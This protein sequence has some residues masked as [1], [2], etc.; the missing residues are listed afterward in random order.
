MTTYTA[1]AKRW[2]HGWELHID[3]V[4]V[5]QSKTLNDAEE[6]VRD[7]IV[8]DTGV[9]PESFNVEIL[10][11]VGSGLDE[12][13]RAARRASAEADKMQRSAAA[14][15]RDAARGL[16]K[17]GL[18]GREIAIVLRVSPQRVSQL[19]RKRT[20]GDAPDIS[21]GVGSRHAGG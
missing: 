20:I 19:L 10:P 11:E 14:Q 7:Y 5:T 9:A 16:R 21:R 2:K 18:S 4:G 6:M 12:R 13:V 8:L 17:A 1:H 15:S 3:G